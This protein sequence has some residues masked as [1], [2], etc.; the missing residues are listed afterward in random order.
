MN[1]V[2]KE[3]KKDFSKKIN[4]E[5]KTLNENL[6]KDIKDKNLDFNE[7]NTLL[8]EERKDFREKVDAYI[9]ETPKKSFDKVLGKDKTKEVVKEVEKTNEKPKKVEKTIDEKSDR[10]IEL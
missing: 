5:L 10:E 2:E 4:E 3:D 8:K 9:S 7:I 1:F 6:E